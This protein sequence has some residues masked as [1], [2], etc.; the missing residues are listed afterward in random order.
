MSHETNSNPTAGPDGP[1]FSAGT[2]GLAAVVRQLTEHGHG[3]VLFDALQ[4]DTQPGYGFFMQPTVANPEGFTTIGERWTRGDSK[5][6]MILAQIV[7]TK[8][9]LAEPAPAK[10]AA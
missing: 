3:E 9:R 6:H 4:T 5:N 1:H 2:I 7:E 8:A 10:D